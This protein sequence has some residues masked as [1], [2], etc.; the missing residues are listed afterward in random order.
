MWPVAKKC[1]FHMMETLS[2]GAQKKT[3]KSV[4]MEKTGRQLPL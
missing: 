3:C 2:L 4:S 1:L